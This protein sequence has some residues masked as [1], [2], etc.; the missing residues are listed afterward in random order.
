MKDPKTKMDIETPYEKLK[1]NEKRQLG[2][3]NEAKMTLYIALSQAKD[4]DGDYS[5]KNHVREFLRAL[6]LRWRPKVTTI[7]EAKDLAKLP[8]DEIMGNL[9][10]YE[11]VLRN[12]GVISKSTKEKVNSIALNA[13][14]TRGQTSNDSLFKKGNRFKRENC[15]GNGGDRFDKGRGDRSKCVGSSRRELSCYS[16]GSKNHFVDDCLRAKV[17]KAFVGGALSDSEDSD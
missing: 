13:I 7:E 17:I 6:L 12:D 9:K 10:V 14:V 2:K 8:F 3:N 16:Y 4:L 1:D 15:F 11:M 5:N